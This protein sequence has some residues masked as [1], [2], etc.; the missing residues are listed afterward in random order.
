MEQLEHRVLWGNPK[1]QPFGGCFRSN[2]PQD[3]PP[4]LG[5]AGIW[6]GSIP[7]RLCYRFLQIYID[8]LGRLFLVVSRV[9]LTVDYLFTCMFFFQKI[10]LWRNHLID[11]VELFEEK[12]ILVFPECLEASEW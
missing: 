7:G 8:F 2:P 12:S 10:V 5:V 4:N 3:G 1:G 6:L 9:L 11:R